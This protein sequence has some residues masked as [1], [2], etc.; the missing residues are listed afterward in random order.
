MF[1]ICF[2][3][4][5]NCFKRVIWEAVDP[6]KLGDLP[7]VTPRVYA[8][9]GVWAYAVCALN[10]S[11][12]ATSTA[13]IWGWRSNNSFFKNGFSAIY[14]RKWADFCTLLSLGTK[15]D[16][17]GQHLPESVWCWLWGCMV[18]K[19]QWW[20][21]LGNLQWDFR[22][23]SELCPVLTRFC[24]VRWWELFLEGPLDWKPVCVAGSLT[25]SW[26]HY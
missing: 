10:P 21:L 8:R 9:A 25:L 16:D 15:M 23:L 2:R 11:L 22:L 6:E 5:A 1:I 19:S 3:L 4:S 20:V 24:V 13:G 7:E 17:F 26:I 18:W 14:L 12:G